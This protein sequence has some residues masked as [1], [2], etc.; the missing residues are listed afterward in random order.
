MPGPIAMGPPHGP[1][2]TGAQKAQA[3]VRSA[4]PN[5]KNA[6]DPTRITATFKCFVAQY[7]GGD[8]DCNLGVSADGRWY[9]N[10]MANVSAKIEEWTHGRVK[11]QL[12]PKP[13]KIGDREWLEKDHPP[14]IFITGHKNFHFTELERKNLQDYLMAGGALWVDN[15]LPGRKSRFDEALRIEMKLILPDRDF[16]PISVNHPIYSSYFKLK[17]TPAGVNFYKEPVEVIKIHN[18]VA[19]FYTLNA[20]S[21]LWE[22]ALD[23]KDQPDM[24]VDWSPSTMGYYTRTG[25]HY[26]R[27][28]QQ[29]YHFFRNVTPQ[30]IT[31][32]YKF[33]IN[34]VFHLI[35]RYE[36]M[37]REF[38][39]TESI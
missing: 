33:G 16:E 35:T 8:W 15:S 7:Q 1:R 39:P 24:Q 27:G 26:D 11:A 22:T 10:C 20:Y 37:Q 31:D 14:F 32:A 3:W 9:G 4:I 34:I 30:S 2:D 25:P 6:E 29:A 23:R 38:H 12:Q 5:L 13:L 28:N 19:V 18:Q 36:L 17:E 21:D